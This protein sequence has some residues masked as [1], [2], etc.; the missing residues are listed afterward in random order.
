[1]DYNTYVKHYGVL[2]MHWGVR[3][4]AGGVT[5]GKKAQKSKEYE[6]SRQLKKKKSSELTNEEMQKLTKRLKLEQEYKNLNPSIIDKGKKYYEKSMIK[7]VRDILIASIA[8]LIAK[9]LL[10]SGAKSKV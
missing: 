2:G 9:E 5:V 8:A 10:F 3:K 6:E 7:K 1:M 4:S